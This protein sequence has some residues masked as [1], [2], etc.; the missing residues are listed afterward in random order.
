MVTYAHTRKYIYTYLLLN[1]LALLELCQVGAG[2]QNINIWNNFST[3]Y[4][5]NALQH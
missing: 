3:F 1:W 4:R 2:P 5:P